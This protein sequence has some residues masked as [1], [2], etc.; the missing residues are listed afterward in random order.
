M[1]TSEMFGN[2]LREPDVCTGSEIDFAAT[3][4][5]LL[6]KVKQF[7]VVG[8]MRYVKGDMFGN[9]CFEGGFAA[10]NLAGEAQKKQGMVAYQNQ[11]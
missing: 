7:S 9:E 8:Q 2:T 11:Q 4:M 10:K 3:G 1:E 5:F 6:K